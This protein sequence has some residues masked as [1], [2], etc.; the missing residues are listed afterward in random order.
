MMVA[1]FK[2]HAGAKYII[3]MEIY[4][5]HITVGDSLGQIDFFHVTITDRM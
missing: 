4:E 5:I 3:T 1:L 2:K